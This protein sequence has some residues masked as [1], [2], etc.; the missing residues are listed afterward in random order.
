MEYRVPFRGTVI[1]DA[2]DGCIL[3]SARFHANFF[4]NFFAKSCLQSVDFLRKRGYNNRH[5]DILIET[6]K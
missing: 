1:S 6:D 4:T 2:T 5:I 3:A